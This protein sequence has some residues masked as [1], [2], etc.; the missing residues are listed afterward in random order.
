MPNEVLDSD[1]A[2]RTCVFVHANSESSTSR[3][4]YYALFESLYCSTEDIN[5][6]V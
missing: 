3:N 4:L 6:A 2:P 5:F 1:F